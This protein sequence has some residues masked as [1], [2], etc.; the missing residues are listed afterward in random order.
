M[1]ESEAAKKWCPI[2]VIAQPKLDHV[3]MGSACMM[4]RWD[5]VPEQP[6]GDK[7]WDGHCGLAGKP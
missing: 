1:T 5:V 6:G 2:L 4:W 7:N 3:C